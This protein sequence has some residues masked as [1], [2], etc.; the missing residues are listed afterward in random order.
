MAE[1]KDD[2]KQKKS[3]IASLDLKNYKPK[4]TDVFGNGKATEIDIDNFLEAEPE[5]TEIRET[6]SKGK[7][8]TNITNE[9]K[10]TKIVK[11]VENKDEDFERRVS[12]EAD[13]DFYDEKPI[14]TS[15]NAFRSNLKRINKDIDEENEN[16]GKSK[17]ERSNRKLSLREP[18]K[19]NLKHEI[20]ENLNRPDILISEDEEK[21]PPRRTETYGIVISAVALIYS[22]T[23]ADKALIF[24]SLS[25]LIYLT[26]P[27]IAAPFGNYNQ[28]VQNA[29]KGFS[30]AL[31]F[32]AIF[33]AFF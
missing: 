28:S 26:R 17:I 30:M 19:V 33:F 12:A 13:N 29:L 5:K 15:G 23:V 18:I 2:K 24:L 31:F 3:I 8:N 4:Y 25:L 9:T 32:G 22:I 11:K 10:Q 1:D 6:E 7:A 20:N 27:I 14:S 16:K 21:K